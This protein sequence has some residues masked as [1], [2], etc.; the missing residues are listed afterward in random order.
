MMKKILI[1]TD[2]S[3][4]ADNAFHYIKE[5]VKDQSSDLTVLNVYHP[6][7]DSDASIYAL[8][9]EELE[10]IRKKQLN[11]FVNGRSPGGMEEVIVDEMIHQVVKPG[12]TVEEILDISKSKDYDMIAMGT[13]GEGSLLTKM[14]GS[15][16]I[17]VAQKS[18]CP[19]WLIPPKAKYQGIRR[20]AFACNY[21]SL[22]EAMI[23]RV[24]GFSNEWNADIRF[25]NVSEQRNQRDDKLEEVVLEQIIQKHQPTLSCEV[26][27]VQN[28]KVWE[29][30]YAYAQQESID[31]I[32]LATKQ[33]K[34]LE[35]LFHQSI[36]KKLALNMGNTP[37]MIL[38]HS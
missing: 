35:N 25:V 13:S 17:A 8:T 28:A 9:L 27:V 7:V 29:G 6:S 10:G 23:D 15:V 3:N 20:I 18:A 37:L 24:I 33:R 16:S 1:P 21:P 19:V 30:L 34:F 5:L 12:F 11:Q 22:D 38:H 14:F 26:H 4:I 32:I 2:F 31:L 36:T